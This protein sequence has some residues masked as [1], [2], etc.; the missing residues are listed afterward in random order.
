M[1]VSVIASGVLAL[2]AFGSSSAQSIFKDGRCKAAYEYHFLNRAAS[3]DDFI[4][5]EVLLNA[6]ADPNGRGY[7]SDLEC[8]PL[9]G[10]FSSPLSIAVRQNHLDLIK[11]LLEHG[12]DPTLLEGESTSPLKI[13]HERGNKEMLQLLEEHAKK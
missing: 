11:L 4:G 5:A 8:I 12:A 2:V 13:A 6:G 9:A 7:E 10:E 3:S 1:K